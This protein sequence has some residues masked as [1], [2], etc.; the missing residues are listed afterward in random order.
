MCVC[1][2]VWVRAGVCSHHFARVG[3]GVTQRDIT[4]K[5]HLI[6]IADELKYSDVKA[7][8]QR[9]AILCHANGVVLDVGT[10]ETNTLSWISPLKR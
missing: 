4:V 10:P 6:I 9:H 7:A 5:V 1:V 8:G 2:R 3:L